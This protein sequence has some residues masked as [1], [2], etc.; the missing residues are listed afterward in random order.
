MIKFKTCPCG[1]NKEYNMCCGIAHNNILDVKT[2]EQLMRSRYSAFCIAD[3]K[4]LHKSHH[5]STRP[6][7]K[8]ERKE[9]IKWAKSVNW[10]S[11]EIISKSGGTENW[12]FGTVEFEA[13]Y[14]ENGMPNLIH[15]KSSFEK[16]NGHWVYVDGI[17]SQ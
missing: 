17:N 11:L 15:E 16:L 7:L 9:I 2:A 12:D 3:G 13:N 4:Y 14:L 8:S 6:K 1:S 5:P 10:V